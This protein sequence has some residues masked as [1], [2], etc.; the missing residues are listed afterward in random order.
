MW[1]GRSLYTRREYRNSG[2]IKCT[3]IIYVPGVASCY[4][5]PFAIDDGL[6]HAT[7]MVAPFQ[8]HNEQWVI[9]LPLRVEAL[10]CCLGLTSSGVCSTQDCVVKT[11]LNRLYMRGRFQ[12]YNLSPLGKDLRFIRSRRRLWMVRLTTGTLPGNPWVVRVGGWTADLK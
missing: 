2:L 3:Y 5:L 8:D 1:E 9:W 7:S 6:D 11:S 4:P 10:T 12:G